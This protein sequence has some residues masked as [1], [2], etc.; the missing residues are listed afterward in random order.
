MVLFSIPLNPKRRSRLDIPCQGV[1]TLLLFFKSFCPLILEKLEKEQED[2][3][4]F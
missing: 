3:I 1:S 4:F 2:L